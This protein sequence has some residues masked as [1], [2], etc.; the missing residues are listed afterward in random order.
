MIFIVAVDPDGAKKRNRR[1][2]L[3]HGGGRRHGD[4]SRTASEGCHQNGQT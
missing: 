2:Y 1:T 3:D 4:R